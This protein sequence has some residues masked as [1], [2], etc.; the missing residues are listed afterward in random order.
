M[1]KFMAFILNIIVATMIGMG[2]GA[3]WGFA[4]FIFICWVYI[5]G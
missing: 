2:W 4:Y 3:A 1:S 5:S